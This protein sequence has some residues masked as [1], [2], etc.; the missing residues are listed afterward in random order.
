MPAS[1]PRALASVPAAPP[2]VV[3]PPRE[4]LAARNVR[5]SRES[6][7]RCRRGWGAG[8]PWRWGWWRGGGSRPI[9]SAAVITRAR[10][11]RQRQPRSR[12][13]GWPTRSRSR[14]RPEP[15]PGSKW[16]RS[17]GWR[18]TTTSP[19]RE[20]STTTRAAA[21]T[22]PRRSTA[23]SLRSSRRS[24]SAF[25]RGIPSPSCRAP[26]WAWP[27]TMS[28]AARTTNRSRSRPQS[29]PRRSPTTSSRSSIRSPTSP[30]WPTLR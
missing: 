15:R 22:T 10:S 8:R 28:A 16:E 20:G 6:W 21:S 11:L 4:G 26:R 9:T 17:P 19:S 13:A 18:C 29:G 7:R 5:D 23:S 2:G 24:A 3:R 1:P 14:R 12:P 25:P 27:G 30:R